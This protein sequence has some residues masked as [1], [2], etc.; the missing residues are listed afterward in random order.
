MRIS[1]PGRLFVEKIPLLLLSLGASVATLLSQKHAIGSLQQ[2]PVSARIGNALATVITYLGQTFWPAHLAIYYPYPGDIPPLWKILLLV[3]VL[4]VVTAS[5]L[6]ARRKYPYLVTGWLWFLGMLVPNIGI[7]QAGSQAHADRFTYLPHVGLLVLFAWAVTDIFAS[8]RRRHV[9]LG[10][11][12]AATILAL[13]FRAND[14]TKFWRNSESVW[15]HALAVTPDNPVAEGTLGSAFMTEG[16]IDDAIAHFQKGLA[17]W[18]ADAG[19]QNNF[20]NALLEKGQFDQAIAHYR[21]ALELRPNYAMA[22]YN[23]G[24]TYFRMGNLDEAIAHYKRALEIQ[25]DYPDGYEQLGN[26]LLR[27]GETPAAIAC[28]EKSLT[29]HPANVATRNNLAM[30]LMQRGRLR[31]AMSHWQKVLDVDP[32]NVDAQNDLAWIFATSPEDSIRNGP[33]AVSLAN[34]AVRSSAGKNAITLRTLAAAYAESGK[35]QEA[36]NA[37][38]QALQMAK[39]EHNFDLSSHIENEIQLYRSHVPLRDQA[40]VNVQRPPG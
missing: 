7:I 38:E 10:V 25:P 36:V 6:N 19:A 23:L 17:I 29:K 35:F 11:C 20:G 9:I 39:A 21:K 37:A 16:K 40:L 33:R 15:V 28:W 34:G 8:W 14:Q 22:C 12:G 5:L 13:M 2:I 32:A 1:G 24:V 31:E 27:K 18:P 26:T 4:V 3:T 30:V